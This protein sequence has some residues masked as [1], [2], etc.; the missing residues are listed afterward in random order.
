MAIW[1]RA[2]KKRKTRQSVGRRIS[3]AVWWRRRRRLRRLRRWDGSHRPALE[4]EVSDRTWRAAH[5]GADELPDLDFLPTRLGADLD[6]MDETWSVGWSRFPPTTSTA[7]R[8]R[9]R[10]PY[11]MYGQVGVCCTHYQNRV[12]LVRSPLLAPG[13]MTPKSPTTQDCREQSHRKR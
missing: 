5:R 12:P 8:Y 7:C 10:S 1:D 2:W 6:E 11:G 13:Q 4:M 9:R 3:R